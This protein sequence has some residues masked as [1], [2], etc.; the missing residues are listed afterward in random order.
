MARAAITFSAN[1]SPGER[2]QLSG[3][4][5]INAIVEKLGT[6]D[7]LVKRAPGLKRFSKGG[8]SHCRGMIAANDSTMLVMFDDYVE[9]VS[10]GDDG[11]AIHELRGLMSGTDLVT[12]ARNN[13]ASPDIVGVSPSRGA[14]VLSATGAPA[15]YPDADV[16]FPKSVCFGDGYF[17]F[18][19]GN[20]ECKASGL[21][22]T[23]ING[24]DFILTKPLV[25]GV[26]YNGQLLL[27]GASQCD[28]YQ[29]TGNAE[30]FP[31]SRATVIQTGLA[32]V[33]A[34]AGFQ[35][36]F[37]SS[38]IWVSPANIVYQLNGYS[39]VRISTHDVERDLQKL[40]DKSS[41][42][43]FVAMNNGHAFWV[44]KSDSF[45]WVFDL[46]TSTWQERASYGSKKW[47]AEQSVYAFG[48]WV[49]GDEESGKLF[50]LDNET[51]GEDGDTL[52]FDVT[53]LPVE[54]FPARENVAR[55]DFAM[56]PGTGVATG[57][58]DTEIDP[59]VF[60]SWSDDSGAT[61]GRPVER[62]IGKQGEYKHRILVNRCG[63]TRGY[64]RQWNLKVYDPVFAGIVGGVMHSS[65]EAMV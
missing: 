33:N 3:S 50:T 34:I 23:A 10:L 57:A 24:L 27:F 14:F 56:V 16:G 55:A 52:V 36:A 32:G 4:R 19:Y 64:G 59:S 11:S 9:S 63:R 12:L 18:A 65:L 45:T 60:I 15:E 1:S 20:G 47:R 35:D 17:F 38:L 30:G 54:K 44:M 7:I 29:N 51:Y 31:L 58:D 21:N 62:K 6:G 41:L 43:C 46:L 42:R 48:D 53:T 40:A 2:A 39:P 37:T 22:T 49:L 25:R 61:F 26:W 13:A 5:L 8:Y 28:V